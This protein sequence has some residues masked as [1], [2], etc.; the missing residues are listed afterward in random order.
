MVK[1]AIC[2]QYYCNTSEVIR[3]IK[4]WLK[5]QS[6]SR[7]DSDERNESMADDLDRNLRVMFL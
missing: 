7:S 3:R 6:P 2:W 1:I 5:E 4:R